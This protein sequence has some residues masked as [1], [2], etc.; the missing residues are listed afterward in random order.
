MEMY[1]ELILDL[2][3][4][5]AN[6]GNLPNYTVRWEE[7]NPLCGDT[8]AIEIDFGKKG[9]IKN[10]AWQGNGCVVSQTAASLL[11]DHV[12]DKTT[13]VAAKFSSE[14][15]LE[16]LGLTKLNPTRLRCALLG[17]KTLQKALASYVART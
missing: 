5:P 3:K 1:P 11:T 4:H 12:K 15:M 10:I 13:K 7:H 17:L 2:Y 9:E 14:E 6:K 8:V 16:L